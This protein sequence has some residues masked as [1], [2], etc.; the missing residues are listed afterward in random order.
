MVW[1][2]P[3]KNILKLVKEIARLWYLGPGECNIFYC[4][5]W[6]GMEEVVIILGY[7]YYY[8]IINEKNIIIEKWL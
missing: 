3:N 8:L 6:D 1:C 5:S 2:Y 7:L 4:N